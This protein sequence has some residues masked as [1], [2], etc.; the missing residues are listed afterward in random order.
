MWR[1]QRPNLHC[2]CA[3]VSFSSALKCSH[4]EVSPQRLQVLLGQLYPHKDLAEL[5][6]RPWPGQKYHVQ[7]L[8][9][10]RDGGEVVQQRDVFWVSEEVGSDGD[11]DC[12]WTSE[13]GPG[14]HSAAEYPGMTTSLR[15]HWQELGG[16]AMVRDMFWNAACWAAALMSSEGTLHCAMPLRWILW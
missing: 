7:K 14:Q 16:V 6:R 8:G 2:Q 13:C 3:G 12:R 1:V 15:C 5:L 11:W 9:G 10:H 4:V